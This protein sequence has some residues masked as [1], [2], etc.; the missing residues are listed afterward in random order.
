LLRANRGGWTASTATIARRTTSPERAVDAALARGLIATSLPF[1]RRE[2]VAALTA[3]Y[4]DQA[5][6]DEQ[7]AK[8]LAA[9][10]AAADPPSTPV[11]K[12]D[13]DQLVKT[14]QFLYARNVFPAM[15]VSWGTHLSNVG[16]T[17]APGC[18][19]CHDDQHKSA[20]GRVIRQDCELCHEIQ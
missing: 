13:L 20:D 14:V 16:H 15:K 1:A 3:T 10:Y 4:P 5:S 17:D 9:F 19:R 11:P 7:I 6:A 8:R 12:A 2:A 18:F